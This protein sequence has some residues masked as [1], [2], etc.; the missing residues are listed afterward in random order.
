MKSIAFTYPAALLKTFHLFNKIWACS[1]HKGIGAFWRS[2]KCWCGCWD[3]L[4]L[5]H[6]LNL[7]QVCWVLHS[8]FQ[9]ISPFIL[10]IRW[11]KQNHNILPWWQT[12]KNFAVLEVS[13]NPSKKGESKGKWKGRFFF[14]PKPCFYSVTWDFWQKQRLHCESLFICDSLWNGIHVQWV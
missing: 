5:S 7:T 4:S 2:P 6:P 8:S 9:S 10:L 13:Q 12:L 1:L 3:W 14:L 11:K